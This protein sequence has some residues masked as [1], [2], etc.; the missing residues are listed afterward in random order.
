MN[1]EFSIAL[2]ALLLLKG[3]GGTLSSEEISHS[4]STNPARIRKI[5]ARLKR[6]GLVE[7]REGAEGG[8]HFIPQAENTDLAMLTKALEGSVVSL[9]DPRTEP[10][11]CEFSRAMQGYMKTL[12]E[13]LN[14]HCLQFLSAI[15]LQDVEKELSHKE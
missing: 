3:R 12:A 11:D 6:A 14:E 2:Q 1:S 10:Q 13:E 9:R 8:Y 15:R 7:T 4:V 5:M